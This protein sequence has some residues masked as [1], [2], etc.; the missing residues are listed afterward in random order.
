MINCE[1]VLLW[2]YLSSGFD[3]VES[4]YSFQEMA[5]NNL[6]RGC[7]IFTTPKVRRNGGKMLLRDL[8]EFD[9]T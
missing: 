4:S 3:F 2:M 8:C 7:S 5:K 9:N 6:N 1:V